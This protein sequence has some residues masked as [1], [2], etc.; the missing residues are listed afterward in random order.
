MDVNPS[1]PKDA[2]V[3]VLI[4]H[5]NNPEG[6]KQ[7]LLAVSQSVIQVDVLVVDDGSTP[8]V[9]QQQLQQIYPSTTVLRSPANEGIEHAL[10]RGLTFICDHKPCKYVARLDADDICSPDRFAK[11]RQF[12]EDNPDVFLVGSW[13]LFVDRSGKL[14]WR[15]CPPADHKRICRK[16]FINNMFCHPAVMCRLEIFKEVGFYSTV[17]P[18]AE[19]FALF[20][21]VARRFKVANIPE[22]LVRSFVTPAGISL[23]RRNRQLKSRIR[24]ILDNFDFSFWAFYGLARNLLLWLLPVSF[25]RNLKCWLFRP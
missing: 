11:Q 23:S 24:I 3:V 14:L 19:D 20:F 2:D 9:K 10:N 7:S 12:L 18:S 21:K 16:M 1:L 17:H 13:A 4:P 8:P 25:I 22:Y 15:F 6:L 5:Y